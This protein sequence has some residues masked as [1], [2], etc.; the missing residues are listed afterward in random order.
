MS[1]NSLYKVVV[2]GNTEKQ[3][4]GE[5]TDEIEN[6]IYFRNPTNLGNEIFFNFTNTTNNS[7][8]NGYATTSTNVTYNDCANFGNDIPIVSH[9]NANYNPGY[10]SSNGDI[11]S[12]SLL[13]YRIHINT[14]NVAQSI[15]IG[16]NRINLII[17]GGGGAGGGIT[18]GSE[19]PGGVGGSSASIAYLSGI[20]VVSANN[21]NYNIV[22]GNGGDGSI[23]NNTNQLAQDGSQTKFLCGLSSGNIEF[24]ASGGFGGPKGGTSSNQPRIPSYLY[25]FAINTPNNSSFTL[26]NGVNNNFERSRAIVTTNNKPRSLG[27][28]QPGVGGP[29][30]A[31]DGNGGAGGNND[32]FHPDVKC[33]P[34]LKKT[35]GGNGVGKNSPGFSASGYGCGGGGAGAINGTNSGFTPGGN[36]G[37]GIAVVFFRYD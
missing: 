10:T 5:N 9:K 32:F 23:D 35:S 6:S 2:G 16:C 31:N 36:G 27:W 12:N 14:T 17:V 7:Q 18:R 8:F 26:P 22:I 1:L 37:K 33:N 4:F 28:G 19:K 11:L 34:L 20:N 21:V 25:T 29:N 13:P 30:I 15:P 3:L 24:I